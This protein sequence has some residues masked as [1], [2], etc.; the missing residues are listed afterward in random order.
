MSR[1]FEGGGPARNTSRGGQGSTPR[2]G[3]EE[4]YAGPALPRTLRRAG[5]RTARQMDG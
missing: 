1:H 2:P 3:S 5:R 4:G